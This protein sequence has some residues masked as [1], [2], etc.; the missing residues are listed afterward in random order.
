MKRYKTLTLKPQE[1]MV[2]A[3]GQNDLLYSRHK[4]DGLK[5]VLLCSTVTSA[6]RGSIPGSAIALIDIEPSIPI[7]YT[8]RWHIV[9]VRIMEPIKLITGYW[10]GE[11]EI[12]DPN[13]CPEYENPKDQDAWEQKYFIPYVLGATHYN[14]KWRYPYL[15]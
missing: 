15:Y 6:R 3:C 10:L 13:I 1:A 2:I 5:D 11:A 7:E 14:G 8:N 12:D 9:N 4:T